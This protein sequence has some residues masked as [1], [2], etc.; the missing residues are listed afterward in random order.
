[1]YLMMYRHCK[2][3]ILK[4]SSKDLK[5]RLLRNNEMTQH[6]KAVATEE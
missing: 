4:I 5:I 6:I 3:I 1:M 2:R